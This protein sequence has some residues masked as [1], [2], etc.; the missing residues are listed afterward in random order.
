ML[1]CQIHV[2]FQHAQFV[3]GIFVQPDFADAQHIGPV[4]ELRDDGEHV[5]REFQ[6]LG[7]LGID[8]KPGKMR[9]TKL[10]GALRLV[11]RELAKIIVKAIS[12]TAV[13]AGPE[14]GLADRLAT[15]GRHSD[16][17][18]SDPADHVRMRLD[19]FHKSS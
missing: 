17:I 12:G 1:R 2:H 7:F 4:E 14:R 19:V 9:Q 6:I 8:A 18:I 13:E 11:F 15:G 10:R 5:V 16:I 3:S